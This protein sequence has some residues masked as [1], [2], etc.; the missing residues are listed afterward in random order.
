MNEVVM[1]VDNDDRIHY[2]NKK[3]TEILGYTSE[4]I[5]GQIGYIL[6]FDQKDKEIILNAD[7]NRKTKNENQ[8][9]IS[10]RSKDGHKIDFIVSA[11][12][13]INP[14]GFT[15]GSIRANSSMSF[16]LQARSNR[17]TVHEI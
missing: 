2:V 5:I 8:Y 13:A 14:D 11:A 1:I 7:Y 10:F 6:L 9:E 15:E 12:P 3:F 16:I 4:E 17:V